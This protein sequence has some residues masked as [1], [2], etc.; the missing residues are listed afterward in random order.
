MEQASSLMTPIC[1][2]TNKLQTE[3]LVRCI[4]DM[5]HFIWEKPNTNYYIDG[6][7]FHIM[8]VEFMSSVMLDL[9]EYQALD[10]QLE[11]LMGR[12]F[13]I[14]YN[15]WPNPIEQLYLQNVRSTCRSSRAQ[16]ER[17]GSGTLPTMLLHL[18][19]PPAN[20]TRLPAV[21]A[22]Q[23][24]WQWGHCKRVGSGRLQGR[25]NGGIFVWGVGGI[26][27]DG[28]RWLALVCGHILSPFYLSL[29]SPLVSPAK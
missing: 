16:V 5:C 7:S 21:T 18:P 19:M 27:Q 13:C 6:T 12:F 9:L 2:R 4:R 10:P 25:R 14:Q 24:C 17:S 22:T 3:K 20:A 11:T 29:S 26:G 1:K 15:F 28:V 23:A 8:F